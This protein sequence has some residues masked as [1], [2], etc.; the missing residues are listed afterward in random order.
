M[1]RRSVLGIAMVVAL[2]CLA[3]VGSADAQG[4]LYDDFSAKE[5]DA[6]KWIGFQVSAGS[7]AGSPLEITRTIK[8]HRLELSHRMVGGSS[9]STGQES[10]NRLTMRAFFSPLV[11]LVQNIAGVEFDILPRAFETAGCPTPTPVPTRVRAGYNN[12]MFNDPAIP[13]AGGNTGNVGAVVELRR[14]STDGDADDVIRALGIVYRCVNAECS[15]TISAAVDLGA[16]SRGDEVHLML[17]WQPALN[18][19]SFQKDGDAPLFISYAAPPFNVNPVIDETMNP[20]KPAGFSFRALDLV[21]TAPA[22]V[23]QPTEASITA[24]VDNV[25]VLPLAP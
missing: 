9:P 4:V 5:L 1:T 20:P 25:V 15:Q 23:E 12:Q 2:G 24:L 13:N 7:F 16:V 17:R 14:N 19:V 3:W 21:V 6:T 11:G 18:G 8:G 22:C 10:R